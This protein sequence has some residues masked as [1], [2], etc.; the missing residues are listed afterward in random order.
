MYQEEDQTIRPLL[1]LVIMRVMIIVLWRLL[2]E[3]MHTVRARHRQE[4]E[5]CQS[6]VEGTETTA[7]AAP[8]WLFRTFG[9]MSYAD[10]LRE[11]PR[12]TRWNMRLS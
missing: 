5:E 11:G 8:M 4:D 3:M 6:S 9:D 1:G 2:N 10:I 12:V 7:S